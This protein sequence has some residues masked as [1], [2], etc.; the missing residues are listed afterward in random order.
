MIVVFIILSLLSPPKPDI[1]GKSISDIY[2]FDFKGKEFKIMD[3][4]EGKVLILSPIYTSCPKFC[5]IITFNIKEAVKKIGGLGE[6]YKIVSFSF[7]HRDTVDD[8]RGF[9]QRWDIDGS[10]WNVVSAKK[11]D[12]QKLLSSLDF[13]IEFSEDEIAH[14]NVFYII[15]PD[16]KISSFL[17]GAD[18]IDEKSL[19]IAIEKAGRGQVFG[20]FS[21]LISFCYRF[22][23]ITGRYE[24]DMRIIYHSAGFLAFLIT[25]VLIFRKFLF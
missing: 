16:G 5:S 11:E 21:K 25:F 18:K 20:I 7:D 13:N 10:N 6:K 4:S 12:I 2:V 24:F 14:P 9:A 19:K 23:P 17:N 22:N 3:F 8:L 1:I 15:T